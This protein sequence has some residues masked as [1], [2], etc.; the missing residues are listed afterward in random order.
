MD[1]LA[2]SYLELL[3]HMLTRYGFEG[4]FVPPRGRREKVLGPINRVLRRAKLGIAVRPGFDEH[5]RRNGR[6]HPYEAETMIG[7]KRLENL[8]MCIRTVIED[9]VPGDLIETGVWRGGAVIFMR[10]A[11]LAYGDED[12][13][14]WAADS[15]EGLPSPS[16][17]YA[18]DADSELHT[19]RHFEVGVET[20]KAN[21]AKYGLLDD[22]VK[23][24]KGW[25]SESLPGAPIERISVLRLDGDMYE[26]Q[27]D[28]LKNLYPKLS[29]GGF[30]I[31]DDYHMI[32]ACR[33]AI[34]DYRVSTTSRT[35]SW[36]STRTAPAGEGRSPDRRLRRR[37]HHDGS[38]RQGGP[39]VMSSC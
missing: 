2:D 39:A 24:I 5:E 18:A 11:L 1:S 27:M 21:F 35:P 30:C 4:V 22:R 29:P 14:V 17:A 38:G 28:A 23:F 9:N 31:I 33:R 19:V 7:L 36:I 16:A 12:R 34:H 3:S 15:F 32:E 37:D 26:S 13:V 8:K 20:V 10:G 25:F 6:D